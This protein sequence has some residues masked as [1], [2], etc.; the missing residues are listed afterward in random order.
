MLC[1]YCHIS[2]DLISADCYH[3]SGVR[4]CIA[5]FLMDTYFVIPHFKPHLSLKLLVKTVFAV[6]LV[7]TN[8]HVQIQSK[9]PEYRIQQENLGGYCNKLLRGTFYLLSF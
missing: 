5:V 4:D 6:F 1:T 9:R 3:F 8:T 7:C 2:N